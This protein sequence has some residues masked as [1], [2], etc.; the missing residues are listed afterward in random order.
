MQIQTKQFALPCR[1]CRVGYETAGTRC[2]WWV[3]LNKGKTMQK[4]QGGSSRTAGTP[5]QQ[6]RILLGDCVQR[7]AEMPDGSVD[8]V[9]CDPPYG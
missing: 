6:L 9:V 1:R 4:Q 7:M 5:P 8:A 3:N 2:P